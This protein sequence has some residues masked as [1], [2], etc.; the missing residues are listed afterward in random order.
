[1]K[2]VNNQS[3]NAAYQKFEVLKTNRNKRYRYGEFFVEGVRNLNEAAANGWAFSALLYTP[4]T[5]LS[6]WAREMLSS[7]RAEAHYALSAALMAEL[8]G[9][10]DTSELLAV[11][12]MRQDDLS[13]LPM[14]E[15]PLFALFDRP[16]NKGNLGTVIRSCDALGVDGLILTGHAVD[17]YDPEVVVAGM[18]SFFHMPV[19]RVPDTER[20]IGWM[21][22]RK[23]Q[24]PAFQI[25]GT[26]AHRETNAEDVDFSR[27][28][29]LMI[30][31][32]TD[33][34]SR[35]LKETCDVLATIPLCETSSASSLNVACAA[36]ALLYEAARQ[37]RT[38][39][40]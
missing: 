5:P 27:P 6:A 16:S 40:R 39:H 1:M 10:T 25:V 11:V 34:L 32:E 4:E 12:K 19:I 36:T 15:V 7:V 24:D 28:T 35:G 20:A 2:T 9:K 29:L 14:R 38:I 18:G 30:G 33:G 21:A 3:K 22:D 23:E 26:T 8:S 37:R 13:A 17:L 31:N